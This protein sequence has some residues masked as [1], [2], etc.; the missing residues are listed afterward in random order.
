MIEPQT[1]KR[2]LRL[3]KTLASREALCIVELG[4][5]PLFRTGAEVLFELTRQRSAR[6]TVIDT[7]NLPFDEWTATFADERLAEALLDRVTH[8]A[9]LLE[10]NGQSCRLAQSRSRKRPDRP[11]E[12]IESKGAPGMAE[13]PLLAAAPPGFYGALLADVVGAVDRAG[14]QLTDFV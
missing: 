7:F 10:T 8:R 1:E 14:S 13:A 5:A 6:A 12:N 9:H 3:Q 11:L 2:L 4:F